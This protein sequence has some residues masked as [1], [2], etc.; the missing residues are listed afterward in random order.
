[1]IL[2]T[3]GTPTDLMMCIDRDSLDMLT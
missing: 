2:A 3:E 1:V